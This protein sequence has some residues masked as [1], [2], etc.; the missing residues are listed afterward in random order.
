MAT[1]TYSFAQF[2]Y[3]VFISIMLLGAACA[4][5]QMPASPAGPISESQ[6][7]ILQQMSPQEREEVLRTLVGTSSP[8]LQEQQLAFPPLVQPLG[9]PTDINGV[10]LPKLFDSY[11]QPILDSEQRP[12]YLTEEL[13]QALSALETQSPE[14]WLAND[15]P[16][17]LQDI[18]LKP[19]G[20]GLFAGVPTTFAPATDIPVPPEYRL[21]P[22]DTID[23]QLFGKENRQYS[24]VVNR[25]GTINFP[26]IGPVNVMGET[27]QDLKQR[28]LDRV[29]TQLIG[30]SASVN[31][32]ALRSIQV[33]VL[34]DARRPG[35]YTV[36]SLS[37]ITNAL[38]VSGGITEIGSLRNIQL[39]RN[40]EIIRTIDLYDLLLNGNSEDDVRLSSGD[41]VFIPPVGTTVGIGGFVKR[42]AIYELKGTTSTAQQLVKLAGG[43][44][45]DAL[46]QASRLAR[47]DY[48][49]A[50]EFIN[51]DLTTQ[52][53]LGQSLGLGDTLLVPPTSLSETSGVTLLGH[54]LRPGEYQWRSGMRLTD[55]IPN[56]GLLEPQ[57]DLHYVLIR[58]E[59]YPN[60][61][62]EVLSAD[63]AAALADPAS[64]ENISI[65][66]RDQISVFPL[67]GVFSE[68]G[69]AASEFTPKSSAKLNSSL[70]LKNAATTS[71]ADEEAG[72]SPGAVQQAE[73]QQAEGAATPEP[74]RERSFRRARVDE[75]LAELYRQSSDGTPFRKVTVAGFVNE[76]GAYP[77]EAGMRVSR[78]IKAGGGL[79]E[80]AYP[81][82][83]ELARYT[84]SFDGSE[85]TSDI[86]EIDLQKALAG[87]PEHDLILLPQDYLSILRKANWNNEFYVTLRGEIRFPGRYAFKEGDTLIEVIER[88][89]GL[90]DQA[91]PEGSLFLRTALKARETEQLNLLRERLRGDLALLALRST[92]SVEGGGAQTALATQSAGSSVLADLASAEAVGRLVIDLPQMLANPDDPGLQVYLYN[93][94]ELLIPPRTQEVTVIGEVNFPTSHLYA[95]NKSLTDYINNSGGSAPTAAN[96]NIYVVKANGAVIA[97]GSRFFSRSQNIDP[98]DTIVVPLDTEA[99]FRLRAIASA[100]SIVYN[101]AIAAAAI[102]GLSN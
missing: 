58:R 74:E 66:A 53:G 40:G 97:R 11:G 8:G 30:T 20:Y 6:L 25:D 37:T 82:T 24:L 36:S 101:L 64:R 26:N 102:N 10:P 38:F 89:G 9:S 57:A 15:K 70:A 52:A 33:L 51:L 60:K 72:S 79:T 21:G 46:P 17:F 34:G 59:T 22:G 80:S 75:L 35:S 84:A 91:F 7:Q 61:R 63:L 95:R 92:G 99:G 85:R 73:G 45:P 76:P 43:F 19:F 3:S 42:P 47:L 78:L 44:R 4:Q 14:D 83:A 88:A 100:T 81:V 12:I 96:K 90:T 86:R 32:G 62:I 50:R 68:T 41:V 98:G 65:K 31:M 16:F 55:V 1:K 5:A 87:D 56:L 39:K 28:I 27:F 13:R 69:N 71:N 93:Q 94:D 23:I 67:Q 29:A 2:A 77:Y 49:G 18:K 48:S 54:V